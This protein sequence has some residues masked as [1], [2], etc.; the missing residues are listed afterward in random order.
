VAPAAPT[1]RVATWNIRA[2]IGPQE[3]FPPA[4]WRH[5]RR[6]RFD[7]IAQQI[8]ELDA[9]VV[10]LQEVALLTPHG[11]LLDQ[12]LELA[13]LTGRHVRYA[14]V[15]AFPLIEPEDGRAIGAATWG[16]A[17]LT[18]MPLHDGF[19]AGL[20]AGGDDEVVEPE[21]SG[22]PLAGVTFADA[23]YG[24]REPRCVVGG[25]VTGPWG[26]LAVVNAHLT[27]AGTEQRRSQAD[28]LA[29]IADGLGTPLV[30]A[31]DFNARIE[32][33]DL[34]SLASAFDDAFSEVGIEGLTFSMP[35]VHDPEAIALAGETLAPVFTV[36]R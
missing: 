21:G 7:R 16:N 1:I 24:T 5:V 15:H 17:L 2:A 32:A 14:A 6:D 35:D 10:A 28:E 3:P 27:Y 20:P 9:D 18:R 23:P 29:R 33:P 19:A 31:G 36:L 11:E 12:P 34:Q 30:V 25:R 13:R 4:W 8:V 22:H 26:E